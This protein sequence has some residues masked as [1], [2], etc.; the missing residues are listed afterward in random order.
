MF[1][2]KTFPSI[3]S[4][5]EGE[6]AHSSLPDVADGGFQQQLFPQH[7]V[8]CGSSLSIATRSGHKSAEHKVLAVLTAKAKRFEPPQNTD[9]KPV[10]RTRLETGVEI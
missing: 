2:Y 4:C 6:E 3:T 9:M 8:G 1:I 10:F 5:W 7:R